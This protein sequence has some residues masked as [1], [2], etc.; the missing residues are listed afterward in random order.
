M[1]RP[2]LYRRR[3][4]PNE[5]V[6]LKDDEILELTD[7]RILTRWN[8]LK[9]RSD[10]VRGYS[11]YFLNEGVKVS[12]Y[13]NAGGSCVRLYC[14]IME[15]ERDEASDAYIF[16]DLLIDIVVGPDGAVKVTDL[17]ELAEAL[18]MELITAEQAKRALVRAD[19]LLR[20]IY[21]GRF[22]ELTRYLPEK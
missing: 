22:S 9:P 5:K 1:S 19:W 2:V 13:I 14:D 16:N 20:R 4:I 18:D 6:E 8:T 15:C 3:F 11:V 21:E 7:E 12:R 10:F 17:D